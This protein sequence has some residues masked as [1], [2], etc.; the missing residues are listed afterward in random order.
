MY[1]VSRVKR[2]EAKR[3]RK[4]HKVEREMRRRSA[5]MVKLYGSDGYTKCGRKKRY[6]SRHGAQTYIDWHPQVSN[7]TYYRCPFCNGWH[8]TSHPYVD[9]HAYGEEDVLVRDVLELARD[10]ALEIRRSEEEMQLKLEAI[11]PQGYSV[12]PHSHVGILD[13][14]R[15][16][17]D[18]MDAQAAQID[19]HKLQEPIE[20]G[21][22]LMAG[23]EQ[24]TDSL[25]V[26]VATRYWLQAES[27]REVARTVEH[28][29][30]ELESKTREQQVVLLKNS[31]DTLVS[32]WEKVGVARLK[33]MGR[34]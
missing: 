32:E 27:W 23:I 17:D 7:L 33:E 12:G 1:S 22:D 16:V 18:L 3:S 10:A 5:K 14:M 34:P 25:T 31:M 21:Y 24:V 2:E 8:L 9:G 20:E 11:G 15:K 19:L 13:P 26:E 30:P 4:S 29:I 6:R 28:R